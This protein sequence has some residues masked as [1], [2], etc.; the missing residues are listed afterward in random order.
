LNSNEVA[1]KQAYFLTNASGPLKTPTFWEI[2]LD[3][4]GPNTYKSDSGRDTFLGGFICD[5]KDMII[6]KE[7]PGGL[8]PE[9][10]NAI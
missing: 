2:Q 9:E 8:K 10:L 5:W 1:R 4:L 6:I 7:F 3:W